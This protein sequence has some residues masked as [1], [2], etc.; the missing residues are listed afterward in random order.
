[1]KIGDTSRRAVAAGP[2]AT[3]EAGWTR[4]GE[5]RGAGDG[6]TEWKL[7]DLESTH[8]NRFENH[9]IGKR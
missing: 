9:K 4:R 6:A 3:P 5:V 8:S 1:M 2:R 7:G